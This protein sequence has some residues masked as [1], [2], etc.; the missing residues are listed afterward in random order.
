MA[1]LGQKLISFHSVDDPQGEGDYS[2]YENI[3]FDYYTGNLRFHICII[4]FQ[5]NCTTIANF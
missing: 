2:P 4:K 3:T 5:L 1:G